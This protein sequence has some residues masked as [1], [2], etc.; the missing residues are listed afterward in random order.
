MR[1]EA[2]P[3]ARRSPLY[4]EFTLAHLIA[5]AGAPGPHPSERLDALELTLSLMARHWR[6][7]RP[8]APVRELRMSDATRE[9]LLAWVEA[10][11]GA[12]GDAL[13]R[14]AVYASGAV[15]DEAVPE[16]WVRLGLRLGG[17]GLS[18]HP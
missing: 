6:T 12:E 18:L 3:R 5:R 8:I 2:L 11:E 9:A 1:R 16:G 4:V 15:T 17:F 13:V 7:P 14:L 10:D